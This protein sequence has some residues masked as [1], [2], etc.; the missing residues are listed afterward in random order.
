MSPRNEE[1]IRR[2]STSRN[3]TQDNRPT[4]QYHTVPAGT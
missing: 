1:E 2:I 4:S 3:Q